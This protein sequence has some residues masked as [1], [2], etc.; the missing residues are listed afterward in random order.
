MKVL[1]YSWNEVVTKEIKNTFE[2][3]GHTV[4]LLRYELK[5]YIRD[6]EF[7]QK[8]K[9]ITKKEKIDF[10]FTVNYIPLISKFSFANKLIY[11][12]WIYDSPH[13]T[14]YSEMIFNPYNYI[15]HFDKNEMKK[16]KA[17][18]DVN[19]YYH[20]FGLKKDNIIN[21]RKEYINDIA[22][23][24]SLYKN[25]EIDNNAAIPDYLHGYLEG[26]SMSQLLLNGDEL[27][28]ECIDESLIKEVLKYQTLTLED[29]FFIK[30][31]EILLNLLSKKTSS[32]ERERIIKAIGKKHGISL[33]SGDTVDS[34][35][36]VNKGYIKYEDEMPL[37]FSKTKINI[38]V[39]L[40]SIRNGLS[41]RVLDIL[42][43]GGFL[44]TDYRPLI[45]EYFEIGKEI[46]VF[47]NLED[48]LMKI[49]FYLNNDELR[50]EIAENGRKRAGLLFAYEKSIK[51]I[52]E[53]V[54]NG[55]TIYEKC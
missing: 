50:E 54:F 40:R 27:L 6:G 12:S 13:Y 17:L 44:I 33:Y 29:E 51:E 55:G 5:N 32:L 28:E 2:N 3:L 48:L 18:A 20:P 37:M 31:K 49:E 8:L 46:E 11:I 22:F 4:V 26:L 16:I 39:T 25:N 15:F 23:L 14:L 41:L 43:V 42:S 19:I 47:Y 21:E 9:E 34:E 36:V 10:I 38:N 7:Y 24:G 53:I 45:E 1:Y 35:G 30:E 52:L